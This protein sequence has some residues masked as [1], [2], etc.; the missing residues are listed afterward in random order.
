MRVVCVKKETDIDN[1]AADIVEETVLKKPGACIGLATGSSPLGTYRQLIERCAAGRLSFSENRF[2]NLDEYVGLAP[3]HPKSFRTCLVENFLR[4]VDSPPDSLFVAS[5]IGDREKNLREFAEFLNCNGRDIQ[6]LGVGSD[7]HLGFNEPAEEL[8]DSAHY[9]RLKEKT[10]TDNAR[11]FNGMD[12]VPREAITM[13]IGDIL[14]ADSIVLIIKGEKTDAVKKL[15]LS[16]TVS[17]LCPV[18]FLRLH[19]DVTVLL[20]EEAAQRAAYSSGNN[21]I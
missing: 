9:E 2:V 6:L 15:L 1:I 11:F 4:Y 18:T 14:R 8:F 13:G 20:T 7:G 19:S 12:E 17:P 10:I 3:E 5:G 21:I 16:E